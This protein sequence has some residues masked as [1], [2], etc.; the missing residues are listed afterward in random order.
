[1]KPKRPKLPAISEQVKAWSAAL[2]TETAA[3]PDVNMK[4][5]FGF[6]A[7]YRGGMIFAVLPRTRS[8]EVPDSFAFKFDKPSSRAHA[9]L[10]QDPRITAA[11]VQKARWFAF[12]LRCDADLHDAL[13]WLGKAYSAARRKA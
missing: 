9:R 11:E 1:M 8:L 10:K 2:A 7:L 12:V 6:T 5:F 3:W 4:S 13:E